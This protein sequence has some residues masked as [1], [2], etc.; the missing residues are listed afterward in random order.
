MKSV[1]KLAGHFKKNL[2]IY[3]VIS[4]II[5]WIAGLKSPHFAKVHAQEIKLLITVCVFFLIYPMMV[6]L[7]LGML[8][9]AV[10]K[11]GPVLVSFFYNF[12]LTPIISV[13]LAKLFIKN[14][15]L[16]LGFF[17][18][19]LVPGASTSIAYTGLADGSI[20]VATVTLAANFI[21]IPFTLP[22]FMKILA[23]S[24]H[25]P[26]PLGMMLKSILIVLILPMILGVITR[27]III[28]AKGEEGLIR[29]KPVLSIIAMLAL[30]FIVALIFF[31]KA[32]MLLTKWKMLIALGVIT[33]L[34][35]ILM[36]YVITLLD[37]HLFKLD[38]KKHMGIVFLSTGK[39]NGTAIAIAMLMSNPLLAIPAAILPLFQVIFLIGYL[40]MAEKI[41]KYFGY[42]SDENGGV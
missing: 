25:V 36:L 20:E 39:N 18:V 2:F 15:V 29:L 19:M 28:R 27:D 10:K 17:L 35:I 40:N 38:Y 37:K 22:F 21:A 26:L 30:F 23:S 42:V 4:I 31:M 41:K 33:L 1:A 11:P 12:I 32:K 6:N 8:G 24:Y 5:G 9:K 16:A 34:Y 7:N 13:I 14:P 3:T